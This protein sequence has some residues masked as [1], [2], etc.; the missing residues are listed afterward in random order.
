LVEVGR[1]FLLACDI[2][3][4]RNAPG[5][6]RIYGGVG[7]I[8]RDNQVFAALRNDFVGCQRVVAINELDGIEGLL[9]VQMIFLFCAPEGMISVFNWIFFP[10]VAYRGIKASVGSSL[11]P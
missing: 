10:K 8:G 2:A 5:R 7:N 9:L 11:S 1:R 4:E 3:Y 6:V